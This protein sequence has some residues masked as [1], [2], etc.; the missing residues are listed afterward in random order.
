LA[1]IFVLFAYGGWNEMAYLAAEL[2][3]PERNV[4]RGLL[5][6]T[7][8]VTAIYLLI[9][10]AFL[11]ALGHGGLASSKAVAQ[12]AVAGRL[13]SH[14]GTFINCLICISTLGA[15]NGL[16]FAGSRIS[17]AM[18]RDHAFFG[19][20]GR[21]H[22]RG[23]PRAALIVQGIL[24][25]ALVIIL[26]EVERTLLYT[27]T[28]VYTFYT[29]TCLSVIV[30]RRRD[31]HTH[32]PYRVTGYPWTVLI[33]A[34]TSIFL[35]YSAVNYKPEDGKAMLGVLAFGLLLYLVQQRVTHSK[36]YAAPRENDMQLQKPGEQEE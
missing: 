12:D 2:R 8:A 18:G 15:L 21:F 6:G 36:R 1:L 29:A 31:P 30:L 9:N 10:C 35:F 16:I 20:L 33:F 34:A 17:Y 25:A 24:A 26:G 27:A 3:H 11:F 22:V 7:L 19:Y 13:P 5:L 32:R 4:L 14:G 28:A 23:A